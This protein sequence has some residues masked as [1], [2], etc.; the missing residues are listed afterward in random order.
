[1]SR[2]RNA[3]ERE[4]EA[5]QRK[6]ERRESVRFDRLLRSEAM[7]ERYYDAMRQVYGDDHG[8]YV[9][10]DAQTGW[11]GVERNGAK[12]HMHAADLDKRTELLYAKLHEQEIGGDAD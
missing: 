9:T 2:R 3:I 5:Q 12:E 11:Y 1:M 7:I 4:R 8:A 10:Y 6:A